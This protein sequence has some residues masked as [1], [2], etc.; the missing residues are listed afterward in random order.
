MEEKNTTLN[1]TRL[2]FAKISDDVESISDSDNRILLMACIHLGEEF[3][4][5]RGALAEVSQKLG[6]KMQVCVLDEDRNRTFLRKYEIHGTPTYIL[7]SHG[8]EKDR[9]LGKVDA[10]VLTQFV[11]RHLENPKVQN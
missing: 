9:L 2:L 1:P 4:E 7:F 11:Q 3:D 8:E 5:Q 6:Q 10:G